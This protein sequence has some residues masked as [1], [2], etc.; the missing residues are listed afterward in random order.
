LAQFSTNKTGG[1]VASKFA[2]GADKVA[3][4]AIADYEKWQDAGRPVHPADAVALTRS[5]AAQL[6]DHTLLKPEAGAGSIQSL[7]SEAQ[8]HHF[9]TVCVHSSWVGVCA[10]HLSDSDVGVCAVAG[11]PHGTNLTDSKVYEARGAIAAGASEI[12]IVQHVGRL[13]DGNYA[14]VAE[15]IRAVADAC[16]EQGALLKVII[17]T[18]LLSD[19][20]KAAACGLAKYA[21]ADFVKTSTGFN[22]PG[23]TVEDVALMRHVVG[24]D[25]GVKAA[26]GVRTFDDL[27]AMVRA[28]ATRIGASAGVQ[29]VSGAQN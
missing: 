23:A 17:E 3:A 27:L 6:I 5:Q 9:A 20:E 18:C 2:A 14:Y 28:G 4:D 12:D 22:G 29:I 19:V 7:C 13:K 24:P 8:E 11:F 1:I 26:G 10:S 21:G 25:I 16:H 15:D